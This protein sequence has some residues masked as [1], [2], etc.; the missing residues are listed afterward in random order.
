MSSR[1]GGRGT[2]KHDRDK[3]EQGGQAEIVSQRMR[4]CEVGGYES[5]RRVK[6]YD[7][8][9]E[10]DA[11]DRSALVVGGE[12]EAL[13]KR[14]VDKGER[15]NETKLQ[16][17]YIT[18]AIEYGRDERTNERTDGHTNSFSSLHPTFFSFFSLQGYL[19]RVPKRYDQRLSYRSKRFVRPCFPPPFLPFSS[20]P[21]LLPLFTSPSNQTES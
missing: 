9:R 18:P 12:E 14:C 6:A 5:E 16:S 13:S 3:E 19:R 20:L 11:G 15:M 21:L 2:R 4:L 7:L 17:H 10:R 1:R 8:G